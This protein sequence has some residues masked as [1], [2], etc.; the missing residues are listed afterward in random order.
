MRYYNRIPSLGSRAIA[1]EIEAQETEQAMTFE[2]EMDQFFARNCFFEKDR[3]RVKASPAYRQAVEL[4]DI[5]Q[6]QEIA[7]RVI[8]GG[9]GT[10]ERP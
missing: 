10:V 6:A 4:D 3:E 2:T 7:T 9:V 5:I 8:E 1:E